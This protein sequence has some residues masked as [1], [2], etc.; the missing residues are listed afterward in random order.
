[1]QT[2]AAVWIRDSSTKQFRKPHQFFGDGAISVILRLVLKAVRRST[3]R[4]RLADRLGA[5]I[6]TTASEGHA[7]SI[8]ALQ[9]FGESTCSFGE[10]RTDQTLVIYW[11]SDPLQWQPVTW[12]GTRCDPVCSHQMGAVIEPYRRPTQ[13]EQRR[14]ISGSFPGNAREKDIEALWTLRGLLR[15]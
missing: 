5:T 13:S 6:D 4:R 14:R 12:N 9:Q 3:R 8:L 2:C 11:G 7:P 15:G 10:I 1:L